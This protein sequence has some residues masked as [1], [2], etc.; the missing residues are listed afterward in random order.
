MRDKVESH[1]VTYWTHQAL[2]FRRTSPRP[3]S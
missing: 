2:T 3:L 1:L